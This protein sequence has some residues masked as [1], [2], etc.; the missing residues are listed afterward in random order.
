MLTVAMLAM[1][2][3][4]TDR[5]MEAPASYGKLIGTDGDQWG[6]DVVVAGD[7]VIYIL[8]NTNLGG[9]LGDQLYLTRMTPEGYVVWEK[10]FGEAGKDE[11]RDI[12]LVTEPAMRGS[13]AVLAMKTDGL[14]NRDFVV[15]LIGADG[16]ATDSIS[17]GVSGGSQEAYT[18]SETT[19]SFI[20]SG[21][22]TAGLPAGDPA[23]ALFVRFE[24]NPLTVYQNTWGRSYGGDVDFDV[25][26]RTIEVVPPGGGLS[27]FYVFGHSNTTETGLGDL[28]DFNVFVWILNDVGGLPAKIVPPIGNNLIPGSTPNADER[29]SSVAIVPS[30][31]GSGYVLTGYSTDPGTNEQK[32]FTIQ[33]LQYLGAPF[34]QYPDQILADPPRIDDDAI[35]S[36]TSTSSASVFA[37]QG[38]GFFVLGSQSMNGDENI[39]LKKLK[40]DLTDAW[41]APPYFSF[42]GFGND[43]PGAVAE[44]RDG[45]II[46]V[47]T[48]LMGDPTNGQR[49]VLLLKLG[50]DG[51]LGK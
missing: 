28:Q 17:G 23:D 37:S 46:V 43:L 36:Q 45:G 44:W 3:C 22:T 11:A 24:K 15:R 34:I 51:K 18:I 31:S 33:I 1:L 19:N 6:V 21:Y 49:K 40:D 8:G 48:M 9:D 30:Q 2:A 7:S 16:I 25:A 12:E 14:G 41:V 35:S 4:D 27:S 13:L 47:G 5:N 50:A 26:I 42:G 32:M 39:Y 38:G 20:V 29:V 10:T